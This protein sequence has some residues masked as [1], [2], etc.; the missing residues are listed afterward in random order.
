MILIVVQLPIRADR[1]DGWLVGIT[2]YTD[3][4]RHDCEVSRCIRIEPGK[5]RT[6]KAGA[7]NETTPTG[8]A[9]RFLPQTPRQALR[10]GDTGELWSTS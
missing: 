3:A 1:R 4:V 5:A 7:G 6:G 9:P 2:R 8:T 10:F